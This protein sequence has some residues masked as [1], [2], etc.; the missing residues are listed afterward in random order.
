M[1]EIEERGSEAVIADAIA[2]ALDGPDAIYLSVD[3]DVVDPGMAPGT[4]TPESGGMLAR[5]LLRAIRQ[6]VRDVDLV[7]MDVVEVSPPYDQGE[8]TAILAHRCVLE[9]ISSLAY[10]ARA[11]AGERG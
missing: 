1:V 2:E 11:I 9:A 3:I 10:R 7:G 8:V 4:G 5:E 6:I